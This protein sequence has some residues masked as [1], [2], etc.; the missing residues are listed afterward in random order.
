MIDKPIDYSQLS[1]WGKCP[2]LWYYKYIKGMDF[3]MHPSAS[4][5]SILIHKPIELWW[6]DKPWYWNKLWDEFVTG[7]KGVVDDFYTLELAQ[8]AIEEWMREHGNDKE[9]YE[10]IA[11][12]GVRPV[13]AVPGFVT[14]P[15][16]VVR[17]KSDGLKF[18]RDTKAKK[19][20]N[21]ALL[22]DRQFLGQV[23]GYEADGFS[24]DLILIT[25]TKK[26]GFD[27]N[28]Q[29]DEVE[30]PQDLLDEW[31]DD[32]KLTMEFM[33]MCVERGVYPKFSPDGCF[34]FPRIKCPAVD[35]C[36]MGKLREE[37]IER[38]P[39]KNPYDYLEEKE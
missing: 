36:P 39:K 7:R 34:P 31:V 28:V 32:T 24:R 21:E 11:A 6:K 19:Y 33:R 20:D 9:K 3:E 1:L 4:W 2:R 26:E 30:V 10:F 16:L 23:L 14:K 27:I 12:E 22:F 25:H 17:R 38:F 13:A 37:A 29:R 15:D 35:F 8:L 18:V 5:S